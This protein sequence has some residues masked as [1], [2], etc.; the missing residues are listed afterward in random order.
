MSC[1]IP[2]V[3]I[4]PPHYIEVAV[5][6]KHAMPMKVVHF[7]IFD[8]TVGGVVESNHMGV[9]VSVIVVDQSVLKRDVIRGKDFDGIV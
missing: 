5:I 4:E 2:R 6:E 7:G 1:P 3:T 8:Q 9:E